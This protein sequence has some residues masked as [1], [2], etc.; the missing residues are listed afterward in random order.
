VGCEQNTINIIGIMQYGECI[1]ALSPVQEGSMVCPDS[2]LGPVSAGAVRFVHRLLV[3]SA[4]QTCSIII[5]SFLTSLNGR[6]EFSTQ[7]HS[8]ICVTDRVPS[9]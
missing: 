9:L 8:P 2:R 6:S 1:S 3:K 4:S 7:I 5:R